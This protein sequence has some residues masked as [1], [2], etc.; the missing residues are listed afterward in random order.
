MNP[1]KSADPATAS[2]D[3]DLYDQKHSF[4]W[5]YGESALELLAPRPGERILDLGCGTGHLTAKIAAAGATVHGIDAS[6]AMI[7]Q[8]RQSYP[9]L[10]FELADA[11]TFSAAERFDAVFSNAVLHWVKEQVQVI[12][13]VCGALRPGGRFVAELGGKG[14]V[15]TIAA[16]LR[17][18]SRALLGEP[19]DHPWYYPSVAEYATLLERGGLEVTF[20][21]L[22][23]RPTPLEG[24]GG[25]RHWVE[26]F[27][28]SFQERVPAERRDEFLR[29]VEERTR[30]TLYCDG[31]WYAD[32]RRLRVVAQKVDPQR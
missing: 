28:K 11:R 1:K 17:E 30:P 3:S 14:N 24:E 23:D 18:A 16:A 19:V 31:Q 9:H 32:Y 6:P 26:M 21:V 10:H 13:A 20:A 29:Q 22:F 15:R 7:E 5:K 25:M 8:A 2:W 12:A 4:V 27:G